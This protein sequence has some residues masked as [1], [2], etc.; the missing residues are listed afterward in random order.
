MCVREKIVAQK[1]RTG[2]RKRVLVNGQGENKRTEKGCTIEQF[3]VECTE[4][5]HTLRVTSSYLCVKA[6]FLFSFPLLISA[7]KVAFG[8]IQATNDTSVDMK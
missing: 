6:V 5:T 7:F 1:A 3:I 4:H 8:R 2:E